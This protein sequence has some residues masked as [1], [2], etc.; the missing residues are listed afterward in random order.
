MNFWAFSDFPKSSG[1]PLKYNK[2]NIETN[3]TL[4]SLLIFSMLY[5]AG[6]YVLDDFPRSREQFSAMV[7]RNIIPDEVVCMRDDSENGEFLLKRWYKDNKEGIIHL[8]FI[9]FV[10]FV[11]KTAMKQVLLTIQGSHG[12]RK[13]L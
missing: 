1:N 4:A 11:R 10:C 9:F 7:E 6:F 8:A 12:I 13:A 2:I 3:S 5:S